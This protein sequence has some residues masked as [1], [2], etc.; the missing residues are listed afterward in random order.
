MGFA[1][2][3]SAAPVTRMRRWRRGAALACR[4]CAVVARLT[5]TAVA[6]RRA[7]ADHRRRYLHRPRSTFLTA[8]HRRLAEAPGRRGRVR[9][10]GGPALAEVRLRPRRRTRVRR[11]ESLPGRTALSLR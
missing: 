4:W 2:V 11:T 10:I 1:P 5:G 9:W 3:R 6:R 7:F 8:L